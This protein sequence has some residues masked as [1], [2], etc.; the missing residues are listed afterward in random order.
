MA[1][2]YRMI[3]LLTIVITAIALSGCTGSS[4]SGPSAKPM[5]VNTVGTG[6][7]QVQV[8]QDTPVPTPMI[9]ATPTPTPVP[10]PI[11]ISNV[12]ITGTV[13]SG[14]AQYADR[15]DTAKFTITNTGS[16]TLQDLVIVYQVDTAE[17]AT[18]GAGTTSTDVPRY[19]NTSEGTLN[20]GD[21]MNLVVTAPLYPALLVANVTITAMWK[22]GS[23]VMYNTTLDPNFTGGINPAD[24]EAVMQSGS[25]YNP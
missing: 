11:S 25:A 1:R 23:L 14:A 22:G 10:P 8:P 3:I 19:T 21:S 20:P 12:N 2:S 16:A 5:V 9:T 4:G 7:A 13:D 18:S 24:A 15:H 6:P 17:T